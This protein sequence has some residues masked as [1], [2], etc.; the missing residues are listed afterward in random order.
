MKWTD[1]EI[2][3][4]K[5]NYE[6][7]SDEEMMNL[8]PNRTKI[9]IEC[10][11]KKLGLIRS[12]KKYSFNDVLN[13]FAK[14]DKY[15]L[16]SQ[17]EEYHDA[18][19]KMRYICTKHRDKGEQYIDLGHLLCGRGCYYCGRELSALKNTMEL[20]KNYHKSLTEEKGFE[21]IDT[22]REDKKVFIHFICPNHREFG[23]QRMIISGMQR[24]SKGCKYCSGKELP[25]WYIMEKAKSVNPYIKLLEPYVNMT[26]SMECYCE[27]HHIKTR[28]TMQ[29]ILKGQGCKECGR[30]KLSQLSFL[31]DETV[32][33]RISKINPHIQLIKYNGANDPSD[34]YCTKHDKYF[35]K[36]LYALTHNDNSGCDECNKE[37]VRKEQG[38]GL[39]EFKRRLQL[40]HPE[41]SV[42]GEYIT[43]NTPIEIY[44]TKH[45]YSFLSTPVAVLS[46]KTCCEKSR[47]TYKENYV[48]HI[49]EDKF[50][51]NITRQKKFED[52]KDKRYLPFDIYLNDIHV[53]IEY[54]GEQHYRP[55]KYSSETW[56][57]AE[58]KFQYTKRHDLIK[59]EYCKKNK[60]PLIEIPY[61]EI[62]DLEYFLFDALV[63]I[64]VIEEITCIA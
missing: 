11:R 56:E 31:T 36:E 51:F 50:H 46:K 28:K 8:L 34:C 23:I 54:Q 48:C 2:E 25:E 14:Y 45:M 27:K 47:V 38:M 12:L 4:I 53:L 33:K 7:M 40:I 6:S 41:L 37:R 29:Q 18:H 13:E 39:D 52:C 55:V 1:E 5:N 15:I 35:Q 24:N 3:I 17:E 9:S 16:L 32:Q 20:D 59:R 63:K 22:V 44:C 42:L 60:I 43:N 10:K 49:L 61:W 57:E 26:T 30:E 19:S 21:Y 58:E 64:N 62:D